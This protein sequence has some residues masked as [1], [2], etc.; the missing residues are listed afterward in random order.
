MKIV[1]NGREYGS[2]DEMPSD[3]RAVYE[4]AVASLSGSPADGVH[5]LNVKT[6]TKLVVNGKEYGS[7][8]DVPKDVRAVYDFAMQGGTGRLNFGGVEI[9][10]PSQAAWLIAGVVLGAGLVLGVLLWVTS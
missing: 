7:L 6:T 1:F 4:K 5:Q 8:D 10:A 3:A 9:G 2:V